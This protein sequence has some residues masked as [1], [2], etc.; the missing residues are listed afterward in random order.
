MAQDEGFWCPK[1]ID[2]WRD[3]LRRGIID[4]GTLN[5]HR[6]FISNIGYN[7]QYLE[8]LNYQN[9]EVRLHA[10]V[11]TQTM[12]SF[13]I[14]GMGVIEALMS[15]LLKRYG[16]NLKEYWEKVAELQTSTYKENDIKYRIVNLIL[17]ELDSPAEVEM[18]LN[19][20]LRRV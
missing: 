12:K 4:N 13:V 15:Y 6:A 16:W 17:K 11:N 19:W 8:F 10:I 7:L 20:M 3:F 1:L 2:T 14:T 18:H 9:H 5:Y